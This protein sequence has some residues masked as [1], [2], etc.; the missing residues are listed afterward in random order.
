MMIF[1]DLAMPLCFDGKYI[2]TLD[3]NSVMVGLA[4]M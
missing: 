1:N 3:K 2:T 4:I